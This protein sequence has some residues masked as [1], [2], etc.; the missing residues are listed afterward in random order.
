MKGQ[1]T[2]DRFDIWRPIATITAMTVMIMVGSSAHAEGQRFECPREAPPEWGLHKPAPLDQVAVLSQPVGQPIDDSSPSSLVPDRGFA[3]RK[4]WHNIWLMGDEPGWSHR[5]DCQ[6]RGSP[7][8]LRLKAD[9]LKQCEQTAKPYSARG[10]I[11]EKAVHT[12]VCE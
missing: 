1:D 2:L 5:V 7:R 9:G 8:I 4:V 12:M 10:G 11:A 6:Y 3:R